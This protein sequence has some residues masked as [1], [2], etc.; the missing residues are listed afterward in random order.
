MRSPTRIFRI[1]R[2]SALPLSLPFAA[3]M[4]ISLSASGTAH[5]VVCN[6]PSM[7][8]ATIQSA[9]NDMAC[10]EIAIAAGVYTEQLTIGRAASIFVH[11]VGAGRT[12]IRSPAVRAASTLPTTFHPNYT[13]VIQVPPG[14]AA[15]F[16]DL[17][18]DALGNSSC[19]EDLF[20]VRF[21]NSN[22]SVENVVIENVRS[23]GIAFGCQ[24]NIALAATGDGGG[25]ASLTVLH[26]TIRNFQKVGILYNGNAS[27]PVQN[28]VVRG[29][30]AQNLIAQNGIQISRGA[31]AG[32]VRNT[33]TNIHYT[34]DSCLGTDTQVGSGIL[35]YQAG[36]TTLQDNIITDVD[37]GIFLREN[38]GV[39]TI[40]HNRVINSYAGISS[41]RNAAG[42][43]SLQDNRVV[44][45]TQSPALN[46]GT[47]CFLDTGNAY[48]VLTENGTSLV[49]NWAADSA[50]NNVELL[51]GATG[52]DVQQNFFTRG[53][54]TDIENRGTGNGI[55]LNTC[56]SSAP[57]GLC[58]YAP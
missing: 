8:Y 7:T 40:F 1:A 16:T 51:P 14:L 48:S 13:Y 41:E 26:S 49:L 53:A 27:G 31:Q 50:R 5:A 33:I 56:R 36:A 34:G 3:A 30:G 54:R 12:I 28:T 37:R 57:A 58:A 22:G 32:L 44:G 47:T 6:V 15:N 25:S 4:A 20:A 52:A 21:N 29:V 17:T 23:P 43:V 2:P 38:T 35:L 39:Q 42:V 18:V 24:N 55:T 10:T 11:G 9:A 19:T 45:T 46:A